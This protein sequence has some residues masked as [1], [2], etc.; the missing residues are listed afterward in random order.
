MLFILWAGCT[1]YK[2]ES[3]PDV[4]DVVT[5]PAIVVAPDA[6]EFP[7]LP[8]GSGQELSFDVT[9]EGTAD[10]EVTAVALEGSGAFTVTG[11]AAPYHL[12]PGVSETYVVHFTPVNA[13]DLATIH[14]KNERVAIDVLARMVQFY[15]QLIKAW[16]AG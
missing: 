5:A 8:A 15:I 2:L 6:L 10:L 11:P 3:R 7:A 12:P 13:E 16:A 14:N 4:S 1:D 9:N